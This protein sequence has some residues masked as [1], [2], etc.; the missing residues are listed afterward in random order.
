MKSAT[1]PYM[2]SV[3]G[4]NVTGT[5]GQ[6]IDDLLRNTRLDSALDA[7]ECTM[8]WSHLAPTCPDTLGCFPYTDSD[9]FITKSR[10]H[11]NFVGNQKFGQRWFKKDGETVKL[12]SLP[13]FSETN[14]FVVLN[15]RT[16]EAKEVFFDGFLD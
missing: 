2:F 7:M 6:N 10:P 1:N 5:S 8:R 14:S 4:T 13:K 9:P 12:I 11:V 15:L 16:L 3:G